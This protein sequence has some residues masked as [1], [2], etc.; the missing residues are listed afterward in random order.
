M[1]VDW[2]QELRAEF[3][4]PFINPNVEFDDDGSD[5]E[6]NV[7]DA[8]KINSKPAVNSGEAL[9]MLDKLQLFFKEND[10]ENEVLRRVVSLTKKVEKMRIK[11][12]KEKIISDFF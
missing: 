2:R 4:L 5:F 10:A 12:K 6:E 1:S 8:M 11:S 3:I 9:T 7:D